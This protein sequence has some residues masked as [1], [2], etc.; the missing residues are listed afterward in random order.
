MHDEIEI[1]FDRAA[2][3]SELIE[4]FGDIDDGVWHIRCLKGRLTIS[5]RYESEAGVLAFGTFVQAPNPGAETYAAL[6]NINALLTDGEPVVI[7][8]EADDKTVV[9]RRLLPVGS[10]S[11]AAVISVVETLADKTLLLHAVVQ[12]TGQGD[13]AA[14]MVRD[15]PT[16]VSPE[17]DP[18]HLSGGP[19][20]A[21]VFRG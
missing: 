17:K 16:V 5:A 21:I 18:T 7:G 13:A 6:L 12:G 4:E 2:K 9:L 10:L 3:R 1:V 11:D 14:E 15:T 19:E 8:L 20:D